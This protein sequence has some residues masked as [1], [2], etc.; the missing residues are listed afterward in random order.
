MLCIALGAHREVQQR[1]RFAFEQFGPTFV[2]LAQMLST[3]EDLLPPAW[4]TELALLHSNASPVPFNDLLPQ[5]EQ[6]LG[7]FP[8]EVFATSIAQRTASTRHCHINRFYWSVL[9]PSQEA[10]STKSM[11]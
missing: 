9:T 7:H 5:I 3:R 1:M 4:T 11:G 2:K 10:P 6:A 8:F